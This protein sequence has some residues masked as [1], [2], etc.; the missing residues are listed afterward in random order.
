VLGQDSEA[1]V[2]LITDRRRGRPYGLAG[3]QAGQPGQNLLLR[4]GIETLLPGKGSVYLKGG[5]ILSLRTPGGG[6]YG[7]EELKELPDGE[8]AGL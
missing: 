8:S 7:V 6:G 5:D 1:Q 2:T 3:G 4:E